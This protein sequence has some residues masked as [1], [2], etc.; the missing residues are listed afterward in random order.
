MITYIELLENGR[1]RIIL[2]KVLNNE[3]SI[4]ELNIFFKY[5]LEYDPKNKILILIFYLKKF[6]LIYW[7]KFK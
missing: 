4:I 6:K 7:K 2:N 3:I 5:A 1:Y